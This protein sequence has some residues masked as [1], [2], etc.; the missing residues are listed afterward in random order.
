MIAQ[1]NTWLSGTQ[2]RTYHCAHTPRHILWNGSRE[3][4]N[5][6]TFNHIIEATISLPLKL[7]MNQFRKTLSLTCASYSNWLETKEWPLSLTPC[8]V[9]L[10]TC[11][12]TFG[13]TFPK[14]LNTWTENAPSVANLCS[15]KKVEEKQRTSETDSIWLLPFVEF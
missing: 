10:W 6:C 9:Q 7:K 13:K 1:L 4:R 3:G 15:C 14:L 12:M 2:F 8:I 5:C 11:I